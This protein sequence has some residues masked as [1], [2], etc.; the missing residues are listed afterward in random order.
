MS[1]KKAVCN[2][3]DSSLDEAYNLPEA[4]RKPCPRCGSLSRALQISVSDMVE[5]RDQVRLRH[6]VPGRSRPQAEIVSGDDLHRKSGIWMRLS[7]VID[8]GKNWYEE[9]IVNPSTGKVEHHQSHP[10]DEHVGHGSAKFKK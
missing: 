4:E 3:C 7:R 2:Q 10:L 1:D 8:R 5:L 6:K 9:K